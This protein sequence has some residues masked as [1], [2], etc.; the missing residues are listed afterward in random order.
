MGDQRQ[1]DGTRELKEDGVQ[2]RAAVTSQLKVVFMEW[3]GSAAVVVRVVT[4]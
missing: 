2:L 3:S 4:P 1:N